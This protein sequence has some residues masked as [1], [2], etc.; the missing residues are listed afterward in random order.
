M[1]ETKSITRMAKMCRECP[2]KDRCTCK[3]MEK[4]AYLVPASVEN[5]ESAAAPLLPDHN[6]RDVKVA[7]GIKVTIDVEDLK[8]Q[9]REQICR[10]AGIGLNYGA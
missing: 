1:S 6:Y 3:R 4:E 8:R 5:A 10:Q 9:I 7:D 2:Y